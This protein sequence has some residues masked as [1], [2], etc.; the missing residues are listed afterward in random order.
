M[1]ATASLA[2]FTHRLSIDDMPENT[3]DA[4]SRMALDTVGSAIAAWDAPGVRE[5]RALLSEW[6]TGPSRVWVTGERLP[7]R[8]SIRRWP[9]RSSMTTCIANCRFIRASS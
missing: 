7:Q 8:W 3:V 4:C 6:G 5:L 2:E 1:D 9:T